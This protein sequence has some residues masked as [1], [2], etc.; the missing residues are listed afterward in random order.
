M[1]SEKSHQSQA[2]G[3]T[4]KSL[5]SRKPSNHILHCLFLNMPLDVYLNVQVSGFGAYKE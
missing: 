2:M 5:L 1:L 3:K 4:C